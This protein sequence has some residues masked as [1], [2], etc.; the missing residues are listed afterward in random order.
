MPAGIDPEKHHHECNN[1]GVQVNKRSGKSRGDKLVRAE[2]GDAASRE[3][4]SEQNEKAKVVPLCLERFFFEQHQRSK[5][6]GR[7]GVEKK[8]H[9]HNR[10]AAFHQGLAKKRI[11]S[12]RNTGKDACD[13]TQNAPLVVIHVLAIFRFGAQR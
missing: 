2:Q 11:G 5:E 12:V 9:H 7:K 8:E 4:Q 1:H 10:H 3:K 6:Q 13:V